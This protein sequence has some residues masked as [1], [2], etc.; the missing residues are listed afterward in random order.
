MEIK[1]QLP[2]DVTGQGVLTLKRYIDKSGITGLQQAE[3]EQTAGAAGQMGVGA[4]LNSIS[5]IVTA[6]TEPLVE[7]V[8]C[9]QKYV[10]N[11][12]T[13]ITIHTSNGEVV[14]EHGRSMKPDELQSL[15]AAIQKNN[16]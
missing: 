2:E 15:V 16:S 8:K 12:R 11:Y 1:I 5:T 14:L 6:A 7:L 4:L 9:L 13:R 3:I 10:D